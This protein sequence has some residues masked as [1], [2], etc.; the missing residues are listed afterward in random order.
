MIAVI[1]DDFTGA[2]EIGGIG[3]AYGYKVTIITKAIRPVDT[4]ILV[5][6]TDLRSFKP[7]Q[8][9]IES[10]RL[11]RELLALNPEMIYKKIDSV[12][13]GNVGIELEAQMKI[14]R[15]SKA[16]IIPANPILKRTIKDGVYFVD[17]KPLMESIFAQ[18]RSFKAKSS[19]VVEIFKKQGVNQVVNI[20]IKDKFPNNGLLI[21]NTEN[22]TDLN[23]W[24]QRVNGDLVPSGASGF[25][26]AILA[27]KSN[28]LGIYDDEPFDEKSN[29]IFICG[30]NF[31]LSKTAVLNAKKNGYCVSTMPN[32][33]YYN[34]NFNLKL[35]DSWAGEVIQAFETQNQVVISVLQEP[36]EHS[37][38]PAHI[39]EII[40]TLVK[41]VMD[42]ISI[43]EI[44]IEGGSTGHAIIKKLNFDTFSPIQPLAPGVT[45]M[46]IGNTEGLYLTMKPGSYNWPKTIWKFD[47][48]HK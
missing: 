38:K 35:I 1:A 42:K 39:R 17:G 20:S 46:K 10:E 12:L 30:S 21:G 40:G 14:S 22:S 26:G 18:D 34:T 16:L 37:I 47:N 45:R 28:R 48:K 32:Q 7:E 27:G 6:A 31:P 4:D 23:D 3:L 25:F 15:K 13:R 9:A 36:N 2:A 5:I 29:A 41:K 11:T 44:L 8:A 33:I 24:A 43:N 19:N